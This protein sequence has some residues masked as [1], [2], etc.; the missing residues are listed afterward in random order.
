MRE[1]LLRSGRPEGFG[2]IT[3]VVPGHAKRPG[4]ESGSRLWGLPDP[5]EVGLLA[6]A[7]AR[8]SSLKPL[9]SLLIRL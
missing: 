9:E 5:G 1:P 8:R 2:M 4:A 7:D 6:F 3:W